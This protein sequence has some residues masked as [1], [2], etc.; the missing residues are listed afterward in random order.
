HAYLDSLLEQSNQAILLHVRFAGDDPS[1]RELAATT[2]LRRKGRVLDAVSGNL[3]ALRQRS[4][5][6]D[7]KLLDELG[8]TTARLAKLALNGPE[9]IPA[10]EYNKQLASLEEQKE[11]LEATIS[12]RSAQF[13]A[14][15]QP[16]SLS[17]VRAAIPAD[18]AL[19]EFAAY[20]AFNP[21][22]ETE[23]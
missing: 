2:I 23:S 22:G 8:G 19:V 1:A 16:V 20:S 9:K 12:E 6:E 13:R 4:S 15:A 14:K 3:E 17:G 18:A 5:P 7:Q 21:K 10:A 11:K